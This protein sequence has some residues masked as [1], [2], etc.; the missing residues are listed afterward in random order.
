MPL[1]RSGSRSGVAAAQATPSSFPADLTE[2]GQQGW[3]ECSARLEALGMDAEKADAAVKRAF[4]WGSQV[5]WRKEK[6]PEVPS[7][8]AVEAALALLAELT[9]VEEADQVAT[10]LKFPE[11]LAVKREMAMGNVE[12]LQKNFFLKGKALG[13]A[14]K[15]KP[16][17]L[18]STIDCQGDCAGDCTR[19]FA[20]F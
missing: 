11:L 3:R 6:E 10:I 4:G 15:R 9:I 13:G 17:V 18:G 20:Q 12:K 7:I 14:V 5:Y 1:P 19:C 16:R 8:E 2:E